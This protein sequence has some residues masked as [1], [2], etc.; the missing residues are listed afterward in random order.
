MADASVQVWTVK[1]IERWIVASYRADPR[2]TNPGGREGASWI[3][4]FVWNFE[5]RLALHTWACVKAG[6]CELNVAEQCA[7]R[8]W[9]RATS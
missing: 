6:R 9:R 5:D 8:G 7:E 1:D 4:L 2:E 3:P